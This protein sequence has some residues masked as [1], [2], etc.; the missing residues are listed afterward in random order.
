MW[1]REISK[2]RACERQRAAGEEDSVL[3]EEELNIH[4]MFI[5]I[6]EVCRMRMQEHSAKR[7]GD[8]PFTVNLK[9]F[10]RLKAAILQQ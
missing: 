1:G 3:T 6:N 7:E 2:Q 5:E 10:H 8:L 4:T 9:V